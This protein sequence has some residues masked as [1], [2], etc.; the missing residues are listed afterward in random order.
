M[1]SKLQESDE[2]RSKR[3]IKVAVIVFAIVEM[4]VIVSIIY[5]QQTH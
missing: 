4:I 1:E 3:Q 2:V 5:Y